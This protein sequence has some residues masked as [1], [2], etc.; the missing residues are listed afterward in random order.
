MRIELNGAVLSKRL[1]DFI[2]S[3]GRLQFVKTYYIIDSEIVRAMIQKESYGFNTFVAVRVGEIQDHTNPQNW[4]WIDSKLNIADWITRGKNPDELGQG[5]TLQN[6]PEF[7]K[8]PEEEWPIKQDCS[9]E[10][11]PEE[12]NK[13]FMLHVEDSLIN[14]INI[15]RSSSYARLIRVTARVIATYRRNPKLSFK[16]ATEVQDQSMVEAA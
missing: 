12:S 2:T 3:E 13:V 6:G 8:L 7:L 5:S 4:Y 15:N 9:F 14:H 16:D 11:L 10:S 1:E